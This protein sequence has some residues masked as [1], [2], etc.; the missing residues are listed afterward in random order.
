MDDIVHF[1]FRLEIDAGPVEIL[2]DDTAHRRGGLGRKPESFV[3]YLLRRDGRLRS[4]PVVARKNKNQRVRAH[5]PVDQILHVLFRPDEGRIKLAPHQG[6]G[7]HRR[8]IT[9]QAD[10][11]AGKL[12]AKDALH[13]G[14][15]ADFGPRHKAKREC[16]PRRLGCAQ[17]RL[18]GCFCLN[19][20]HSCMV[21]KGFSGRRQLNTVS[22]AMDQLNADF[23]FE[24]PDLPAERWLGSVELLLGGNGQTAGIGHGDEVA[25]M[26]EL[27]S[28]LPYLTSMGPAYKVFF[29]P[30]SGLYSKATLHAGSAWQAGAISALVRPAGTR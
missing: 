26:P 21:E 7:E 4:Q 14:Q 28:N 25:E 13:L 9:R 11:D 12:V 24:I 23:L 6:L 1:M 8:V 29:R 30:A 20:R 27:H 5:A 3:R 17:R 10:F 19:Q 16:R 2:Q 15:Q 18:L 22:A